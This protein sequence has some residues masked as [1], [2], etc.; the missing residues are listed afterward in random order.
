MLTRRSTLKAALLAATTLAATALGTQG[1]WAADKVLKVG[2]NLSFTGA[3][4]ESAGRYANGA[5]MAFDDANSKH[6]VPGYPFQLVKFDDA[7]PTAGQYDPAQAATNARAMVSD[8]AYVAALG[9]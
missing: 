2:I 3:D 4:A 7:P 5:A 1:A 9:P 8:K 6:E